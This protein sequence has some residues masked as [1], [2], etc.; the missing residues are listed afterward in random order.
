MVGPQKRYRGVRQRKTGFWVAET[1]H[2]SSKTKIWLGSFQT[3]EDAA[4]AYDEAAILMRGP[5][6]ITNFPCN[7]NASQSSVLAATVTE[8]LNRCYKYKASGTANQ[9]AQMASQLP[10][11]RPADQQPPEVDSNCLFKKAKVE[12]S[13]EQQLLSSGARASA[14]PDLRTPN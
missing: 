1:R 5:A 6:T 4:K 2:P 8:R 11:I 7:P 12:S 13:G 10:K 3:A 14:M 9:P